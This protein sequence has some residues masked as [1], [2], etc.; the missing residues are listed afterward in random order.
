MKT[1]AALAVIVYLLAVSVP[2]FGLYTAFGPEA[3]VDVESA[4]QVLALAGAGLFTF[5]LATLGGVLLRKSEKPPWLE[6]IEALA[7]DPP[8]ARTRAGRPQTTAD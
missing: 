1:R 6:V 7:A 3:E 4:T 5:G 8:L 2:A